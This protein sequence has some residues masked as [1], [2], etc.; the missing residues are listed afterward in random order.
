MLTS[1]VIYVKSNQV[2]RTFNP[3]SPSLPFGPGGP[4]KPY[5]KQTVSYY[6]YHLLRFHIITCTSWH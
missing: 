2:D 1:I 3:E 5:K 6:K 4:D